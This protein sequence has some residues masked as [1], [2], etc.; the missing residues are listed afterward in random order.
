MDMYPSRVTLFD[1]GIYRW[2]YNMDMWRNRYLLGQIIKILCIV[3]GIPTMFLAAIV[4]KNA[5]LVLDQGTDKIMFFIH[6][7]LMA[8]A[9][10]GGIWIGCIILTLIIY[11]I[12]ATVMH[13]TWHLC[14]EMNESAVALIQSAA[15]KKRNDTLTTIAAVADLVTTLAGKPSNSLHTTTVGLSATNDNRITHFDAVRKARPHPEHD[16]IDLR[17]FFI[18]NQIYVGPEDYPFVRDFILER[19][20]EKARP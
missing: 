17:G 5:L 3:L 20:R 15:T 4:V 7:D 9:V 6:N 2:S 19:V 8:L 10:V 14:F 1:D 12:C 11:A 16:L 13:G 18:M